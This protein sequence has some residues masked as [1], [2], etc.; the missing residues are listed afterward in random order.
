M[1]GDR[2][3]K[4]EHQQGMK[5]HKEPACRDEMKWP[6][7]YPVRFEPTLEDDSRYE[8][9]K[10][11]REKQL[12]VAKILNW[13]TVGAAIVALGG[14]VFLGRSLNIASDANK[15]A[16]DALV[17][18]SRA[19]LT[20]TVTLDEPPHPHSP[21]PSLTFNKDGT[22]SLN[23]FVV[24]KNIGHSPASGIYVDA[25]MFPPRY[26]NEGMID[27]I[28]SQRAWCAQVRVQAHN[29]LLSPS[30]F[31]EEET[32][33]NYTV[34][35]S[36]ADID[37]SL[38]SLKLPGQKF[39]TPIVYGCVNYGDAISHETHQTQFMYQLDPVNVHEGTILGV[40]LK[41]SKYPFGG[42]LGY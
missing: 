2:H 18:S 3:E 12:R 35:M 16:R 39:I 41:I 36:K 33:M 9:Q 23:A 10:T 6:S 14:L 11:N 8:E 27:P 1:R 7:V 34:G 5:G 37:A 30:L 32:T 13:V 26:T 31:P 19:W 40:D 22:A 4:K 15:T 20:A 42:T 38:S 28:R 25:R 29:E 17:A 21:G 24:L